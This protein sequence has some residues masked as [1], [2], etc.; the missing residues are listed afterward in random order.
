MAPRLRCERRPVKA[1]ATTSRE[2]LSIN[3]LRM[4]AL[5]AVEQAKSGH[6][7]MPMGMAPT[8]YVLWTEFLKHNPRDP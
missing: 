1:D 2:T 6:P 7:G 8:A 3:A 5:D 4:L